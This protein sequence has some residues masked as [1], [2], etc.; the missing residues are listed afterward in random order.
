MRIIFI[1]FLLQALILNAREVQDFN[2]D[3][4]FNLG[5]EPKAISAAYDDSDWRVLNLPH[6]W[7]IEQVYTTE[8]T[9]GSTGFLPGGIGWYRKT[10]TVPANW[11]NTITHIEFDGVYR[12]SEVWVNGQLLGK[13]PYGYSVFGYD[14]TPHLKYGTEN[15]LTV[16]VDHSQFADSRWYTGSGI[17]RNVRLVNTSKLYVPQFGGWVET[18]QV[19]SKLAKVNISAV[20]KNQLDKA[21]KASVNIFIKDKAGN[22]VA[23]GKKALNVKKQDTTT[24]SLSV[25]NPKLWS[26]EETNMYK[27]E[28]QIQSGKVILD[29][30]EIDFGIRSIRFDANNGFFLNDKH[31]KMKG[32]CLHHDA[33]AVGAIFIRDIWERRL[34]KLKLMGC[35]AIRVSHNPADP[36]LLKLCDEMGFVVINE[37]FDEWRR[38]KE[39][40][41]NARGCKDVLPENQVGYGDIFEEWG[42][43]DAQDMVRYSRNHPSIIMWSMGNEIEW[44]YPYY[45]KMSKSQQGLGNQV[46]IE[47]TGD[48]RDELKETAEEI[49][50]W[51][52]EI[53]QSRPVTT[54]GVLSKSGNITGYYDVPDVMGYNYQAKF[55]DEDHA[56]YPNRIMYGSENLG[57]AEEWLAVKDRDFVS[58]LFIWTGIA[59]LG[60]SGPFP[61]KGL[62]FSTLD[63][64]G[65]FTPRGHLFRTLWNN[66]PYTY[67]ATKTM[68]EAEWKFENDGF[69]RKSP[70]VGMDKWKFDDV[71]PSWNYKKG[72]SVFVEVYSNSPQVEL[73]INE[74]SYGIKNLADFNED[75]LIKYMVPYNA[76]Q[77]KAVG[78]RDGKTESEY[79][80]KTGRWLSK[81]ELKAD[82]T[83]I[84]ANGYDVVHIEAFMKDANGTIVPNRDWQI[85]FD[86]EGVGKN[87]GV[88]NGWDHSVQPHKSDYIIPRNGKAL[89]LIQS[90]RET[91]EIKISARSGNLK[92]NEVVVICE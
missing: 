8:K 34:E 33:G 70:K 48:G 9:A 15:T 31:V 67:L 4:K 88:D 38:N 57:I 11:K 35:N 50:T 28:I 89:L 73:F 90:T 84:K 68:T 92:S 10:F 53:D 5:D 82:R 1:L 44:T 29:Q 55:Y 45:W 83:T 12:D 74:K 71:D 25:K 56:T 14:L 7:S 54:G 27:A 16:K 76:G 61:W 58:G 41:I 17:Y 39:K 37:A 36:G 23:K 60:E 69:V 49:Q 51:I 77:I 59:Y 43:R 91:G 42:K 3:W 32:V 24:I 19:S 52:K 80:L 64:A 47:E 26:I 21:A 72:D 63:F 20:I 75:R 2:F 30:Y 62:N 40:W 65:F 46:L 87:I 85:K 78:I 6:D 86:I 13:R 81:I 22:I 66:E 18:P 79:V